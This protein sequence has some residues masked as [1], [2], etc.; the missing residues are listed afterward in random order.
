VW[1]EPSLIDKTFYRLLL[2]QIQLQQ[3]VTDFAQLLF[4][5]TS[6]EIPPEHFQL[7]LPSG[8]EHNEDAEGEDVESEEV[9]YATLTY[10][11]VQEIPGALGIVRF[12]AEDAETN[13]Y[14]VTEDVFEDSPE[15]FCRFQ[16]EVTEALEMG[17]D[18]CVMS[19][20]DPE[21]FPDINQYLADTY[22]DDPA[23]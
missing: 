23:P 7:E 15:E 11:M 13:F 16:R 6:L 19:S 10:Y 9:V 2:V 4:G 14:D 18:V 3:R 8:A 21:S 1:R 5:V 22:Q 12:H 17:V 20:F